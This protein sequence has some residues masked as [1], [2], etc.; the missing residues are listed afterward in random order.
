MKLV[1]YEMGNMYYL[2]LMLFGSFAAASPP[3][4]LAFRS[5]KVR[6]LLAY[7]V[8][9]P[10]HSASRT[11]LLG[12]LY[13]DY[14]DQVGRK[15][16]NLT[17][18]RLRQSLA[19]VEARMGAEFSFLVAER[20]Q[21]RLNWQPEWH[22]A[23]V[24][25]F[26]ALQA[27]CQFH[28]HQSLPHCGQCQPRL[29]RMVELYRG[30][31]LAGW[32]FADSPG[33]NEWCL[34]QQEIRFRQVVEALFALTEGALAAANYADAISLA[35]QQINLIPWQERA[36]RQLIYALQ[37][38]NQSAAAQAQFTRLKQTLAEK[39]QVEPGPETVALLKH[40]SAKTPAESSLSDPMLDAQ[41]Q[42]VQAL[43]RLLLDPVNRLIT[44]LGPDGSAQAD[45]VQI[46]RQHLA[47]HF[48]DG[49]WF[50]SLAEC[51][52]TQLETIV[53]A[54]AAALPHSALSTQPSVLN[55][56]RPRRLL[57]IL[58]TFT[59]FIRPTAPAD[60]VT[61]VMAILHDAPQVTMLV[62][63]SRPLQLQQEIVY[64]L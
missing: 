31:L 40:G 23:D 28:P 27:A 10:A 16:L 45:M 13:S 43:N 30:E 60:G 59:P 25:E 3:T 53:Q 49:I 57:L 50:V 21:V 18:T 29:R 52:P 37:A 19:P 51:D 6:A 63:A 9:H 17:L 11:E 36:Y 24:T 4:P 56:L 61:L 35:R 12:L 20:E 1:G 64:R 62:L 48:P 58:D 42:T 8:L 39:F 38:T 22:W 15:N 44:L 55:Y 41:S 14:P 32:Q 26:D 2:E 54:I 7:L 5:D 47:S 34:W 33:F 46:V